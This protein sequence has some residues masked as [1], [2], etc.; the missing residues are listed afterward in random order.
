MVLVVALAYSW[1]ALSGDE[2]MVALLQGPDDAMRVVQVVD[3]LNGQAWLDTRQRRLDPP[4]GGVMHWSRIA[5]LPLGVSVA[6]ATPILGRDQAMQAAVVVVPALLGGTLVALLFWVAVPLVPGKERVMATLL[7]L[8]ALIVALAQLRPGRVDHHGLQ[9]VLVAIAAGFAFRSLKAGNSR[10]AAAAGVAAAISLVVGLETLPF[11]AATAFALMLASVVRADATPSLAAFGAA[12]AVAAPVLLLLT[13]PLADWTT[14][15]CDRVSLPHVTGTVGC[16]VIG[17]TA[18]ALQQSGAT[19]AHAFGGRQDALPESAGPPQADAPMPGLDSGWHLRLA[20]VGV[21]GMVVAGVTALLFPQCLGSPY[22]ELAPEARYWLDHV[23]EA[24]SFPRYFAAAPGTAAGFAALP[25]LGALVAGARLRHGGWTDPL[26][27]ATLTLALSGLAVGW[28][29]IRGLPYAALV[30]AIALLPLT[31]GLSTRAGEVRR[32][33]TRLALRLCVPFTYTAV[34]ILPILVQVIVRPSNADD[35]PSCELDDVLATLQ[36]RRGLGR[37]ALTI[38]APINFGPEILLRTHHRVLAA[39]YHR[40][41]RGIVDIRKILA[42]T[43][44]E[45]VATIADRGVDAIIFCPGHL[46]AVAYPDRQGFLSERLADA[47][48][49]DWLAPV[50]ANG[51]MQL[52]RVQPGGVPHPPAKEP[53]MSS[54]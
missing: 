35:K 17:A 15:A 49:P 53:S 14:A 33:V 42:G 41:V 43:E 32:H 39:P 7:T 16:A 9:L 37:S 6:L 19:F 12:L 27:L 10:L 38:A 40:S 21:S 29:Q 13:A 48:L 24:R 34:L 23:S 25:L 5:D 50:R 11:I 46:D 8:P 4:D 20:A 28:W 31:A 45:T 44:A 1:P 2:P 47:S 30:G 51:G 54:Q 36:D 18:L 52:Y 3:W 22:A 26:R